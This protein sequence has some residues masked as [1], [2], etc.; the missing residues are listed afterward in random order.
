[1]FQDVFI[2]GAGFSR[3]LSS[4]LPLTDELGNAA[5]AYANLAPNDPRLPS[6]G[7]ANR[8]FEVWLSRLAE[9]Q[10]YLLTADN[11]E[12]SGL[13]GRVSVAIQEVLLGC[14]HEALM[15]LPPAWLSRLLVVMQT[16]R[17]TVITL[18]YDELIEYGYEWLDVRDGDGS[19]GGSG[20]LINDLPPLANGN[21]SV[22]RRC[23][24]RLLK[25]HGSLSWSRSP[26]DVGGETLR[27]WPLGGT[28]G[29][30][31]EI[32]RSERAHDLPGHEPFIV[33]PSS[34]KSAYYGNKITRQI[35]R[36]AY[37]DL[38]SMRRLIL[39]G[40]SLPLTDITVAGMIEEGLRGRNVPVYVVNPGA[41]EVVAN[42]A[43]LGV[44]HG[45]IKVFDGEH[46]VENFVFS[47]RN[48]AAQALSRS[49]LA[50]DPSEG[51]V[52]RVQWNGG[53]RDLYNGIS[54][55]QAVLGYEPI[56]E[57]NDI[58]L[59]L[60]PE[61]AASAL[62]RHAAGP[63]PEETPGLPLED[64]QSVLRADCRIVVE[65]PSGLVCVA[66]GALFRFRNMGY[67]LTKLVILVPDLP[68]DKLL[69]R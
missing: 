20:A 51:L 6:G 44:R 34:T 52:L 50:L 32:N 17:S 1:M 29:S 21:N 59:R 38:K 36:E 2:L 19:I 42:L 5:V 63:E 28:F 62:A 4:L 49:L 45:D 18:N 54:H 43:E 30:P 66:V 15:T 65:S 27:R 68:L 37:T 57:T 53:S 39:V 41:Q 40:Y 48:E 67:G 12:R 69:G 35:W 58:K 55:E 10:P 3:A 9:G 33:P 11:Q 60:E 7:F 23:T 26:G 16:N 47:Y 25:L 13:F 46:A 64:L 61:L 56:A 24:F 31:Q 8:S 14:Q 22:S